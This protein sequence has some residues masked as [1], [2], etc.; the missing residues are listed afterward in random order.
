MKKVILIFLILSLFPL[1]SALINTIEGVSCDNWLNS[2]KVKGNIADNVIISQTSTNIMEFENFCW[3]GTS[4]R[5]V[6]GLTNNPSGCRIAFDF[7]CNLCSGLDRVVW[8]GYGDFGGD[9]DEGV[10]PAENNACPIRC[11][12]QNEWYTSRRSSIENGLCTY[13]EGKK[14]VGGA[15]NEF[16]CNPCKD[17]KTYWSDS[18]PNTE[19]VEKQVGEA[20]YEITQIISPESW[21]NGKELDHGS[22]TVCMKNVGDKKDLYAWRFIDLNND[23]TFGGFNLINK[24][25]LGEIVCGKGNVGELDKMTSNDWDFRVCSG[26]GDYF[27]SHYNECKEITI[28]STPMYPDGVTSNSLQEKNNLFLILG[29]ITLVILLIFVAKRK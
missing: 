9:C 2:E 4:N 6:F 19:L 26:V 5:T 24:P 3:G 25:E 22:L 29:I 28:K 1:T 14:Y 15:E 12:S 8:G 20:F 16:E 10:C 27:G 13:D 23:I 7:G 18:P 17:E 11:A 21:E